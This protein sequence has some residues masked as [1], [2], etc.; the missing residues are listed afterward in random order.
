LANEDFK[1][2][3]KVI[4][5]R[6]GFALRKGDPATFLEYTT[7]PMGGPYM[8]VKTDGLGMEIGYP[9]NAFKRAG[10]APGGSNAGQ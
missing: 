6:R 4:A 5:I 7:G 3:D 10:D 1:P 8:T 2:G 9:V